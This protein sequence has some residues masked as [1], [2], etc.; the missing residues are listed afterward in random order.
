M[1]RQ[2]IYF[3]GFVVMILSVI[4]SCEK[5][6][7]NNQDLSA[8][9]EKFLELKT[10]INAMNAGSGQMSDFLTV[11]GNS[12]IKE[13]DLNIP[14]SNADSSY[15]DSISVNPDGYW[16]YVTCA[17]VTEYNNPDGTH[18]TSYDYG[19]GCDEYGAL[20]KGK[21]TYIWRNEGNNYYSKVIYESYYSYGVKMNGMSEYSFTSD[22]YS[23]FS[24][25]DKEISNDSTVTVSPVLFN[26]SGSSTGHEELTMVTD[27]GASYY[28]LSD[29]SNKWDSA[30]YT[31]LE[32]AYYCKNES[33]EFNSE[34]DYTVTKPLVTRYTCVNSWV[35]VSGVE[36]I[37]NKENDNTS[38]YSVDYGNGDC[39]NLAL[40][41]ENGKTSVVDFSKIYYEKVDSSGTSSPGAQGRSGKKK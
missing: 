19:D 27:D 3:L 20:Y 37:S 6:K 28:Y 41:T 14:G 25:G 21:I 29:Y 33:D 24:T 26:W 40:L 4:T 34:Y 23:S 11:I 31:V 30:S 8:G 35:P 1:K 13:G 16:D 5:S 38:S 9:A 12:Q 7:S 18:T 10:R 32:G 22:G 15:I 17:T 36:I 39:D 2:F